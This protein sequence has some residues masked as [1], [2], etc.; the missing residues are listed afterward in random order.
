MERIIRV[1][2]NGRERYVDIIIENNEDGTSRIVKRTGV[3]GGREIESVIEVKMGYER[4][5]K[6]AE[7]IW[8]N[9]KM[10]STMVL[11]MLAN[12]WEDKKR[13][14]KEPFYVQPKIDGVRLIVSKHGCYSRTG[15]EVKGVEYLAEGLK[16]GEYLDGECYL[17]DVS[18]EEIT[19]I[20]KTDPK[21]LKYYVFDYFDMKRPELTFEE[22]MKGRV[23]IETKLVGSKEEIEENHDR[24]VREGYEGIMIRD[25]DSKY[26]VGRRS[27]Y[28]LKLKKF[29]TEEYEIVDMKEGRGR[30]KGAG[31][32]VCKVG[33][34]E[35]NVKSEGS[36]EKRREYWRRRGEYVGKMLTV[37]YQNYTSN[38]VPRFPVG[39][40]VRDYE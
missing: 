10:K 14:I 39:I 2:K 15:K 4:A 9:E 24:Y 32:W 25:K 13:M 36:I 38:G 16:E 5:K 26:E 20:F 8:R 21:R 12:K 18:F 7:T 3:V 40:G 6:R 27:N 22:R 28:L 17:P 31:V 37:R 23:N 30:E 19:S 35:F 29:I 11:P 1:D 33:E 34:M